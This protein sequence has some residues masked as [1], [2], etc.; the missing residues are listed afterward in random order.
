MVNMQVVNNADYMIDMNPFNRV[1]HTIKWH[2]KTKGCIGVISRGLEVDPV[3]INDVLKVFERGYLSTSTNDDEHATIY[4]QSI[5]DVQPLSKVE[6][7][8]EPVKETYDGIAFT[9]TD[10]NK[11]LE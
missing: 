2:L 9:V 6:S 7:A 10:L 8:L 4:L 5:G 11:E 3:A 1:H